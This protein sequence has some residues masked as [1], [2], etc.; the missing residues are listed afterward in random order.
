MKCFCKYFCQSIKRREMESYKIKT[1]EKMLEQETLNMERL[2][3]DTGN[4]S[5]KLS[6][7]NIRKLREQLRQVGV[8]V[9]INVLQNIKN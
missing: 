8:E 1:L 6:E 4:P 5:Y 3:D 7:A 9:S 2:K